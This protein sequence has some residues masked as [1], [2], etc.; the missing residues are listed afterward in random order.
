MTRS[1]AI[2]GA[3]MSGLSCASALQQLGHNV[4]VFD[5]SRG[6]GG[7]M[8][9][10]RG[11]GWQCDHGAQYFTAK[12]DAF[13]EQVQQWAQAGVVAEWRPR[14]AVIGNRPSTS[15]S[16]NS[17][18]RWVGTPTMNAPARALASALTVVL[19]QT[20]SALSKTANG[21][22]L[23][24]PQGS[25]NDEFSHVVLAIPAAQAAALLMPLSTQLKS[26]PAQLGMTGCWS[27]MLQ[28]AT[29]VALPFDAA[30]INE[31]PLSWVARDSHKPDR[32]AQE[33]WLLHASIDWSESHIESDADN[34]INTLTNAFMALGAPAA[35]SAQAHRWRYAQGHTIETF[36][37]AWDNSNNIGLCGDWLHGGR[38]EGAWLSGQAM[39]KQLAMN[40]K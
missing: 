27:V 16:T 15:H 23:H 24:T 12:S 26:I 7:R 10:R 36:K 13:A 40:L 32:P 18:A 1:I 30:F 5:K 6:I 8:S 29:P 37:C 25:L 35:K 31:G 20:I 2:I 3:G 39:A 33:S 21:W 22:C 11:D 38:V 19:G 34:V 17:P 4:T 14:I 28:Y 9:T